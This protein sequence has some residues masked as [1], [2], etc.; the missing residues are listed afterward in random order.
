MK[1]LIQVVILIP[2]TLFVMNCSSSENHSN[3]STSGTIITPSL[4]VEQYGD[5]GG[6]GPRA[7][8]PL[9]F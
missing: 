3:S 9:M 1:T 8:L 7:E 2:I 4:E 5:G 6:K